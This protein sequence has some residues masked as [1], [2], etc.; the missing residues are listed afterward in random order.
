M[1]LEWDVVLMSHRFVCMGS[2]FAGRKV[3][4]LRISRL[5]FRTMCYGAVGLS[6]LSKP[7]LLMQA[8]EIFVLRPP[9]VI[10]LE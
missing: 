4:T 2:A 8:G 10:D 7:A 5:G 3:A 1:V 9:S 6:T